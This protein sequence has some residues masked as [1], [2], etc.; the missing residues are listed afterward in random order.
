MLPGWLKLCIKAAH[1]ATVDTPLGPILNTMSAEK[2]TPRSGSK[3]KKY[4]QL[5]DLFEISSG[6][7]TNS[8]FGQLSEWTFNVK[9]GRHVYS[10]QQLPCLKPLEGL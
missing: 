10:P 5:P 2:V 6:L 9:P 4:L 1:V 3:R 7:A 8:F